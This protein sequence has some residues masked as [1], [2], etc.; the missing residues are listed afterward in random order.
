MVRIKFK[1]II[2]ILVVCSFTFLIGLFNYYMD[3][4]DIFLRKCPLQIN[5]LG[6]KYAN[7]M[8]K[9][10]KDDKH[11]TLFIGGSEIGYLFQFNHIVFNKYFDA[12]DIDY[13]SPKDLYHLVKNYIKLHPET[14]NIY[15]SIGYNSILGAKYTEIPEFSNR[16]FTFN[17][18]FFIFVSKQTTLESL[19]KLY[20]N[21]L[22][23]LKQK[24]PELYKTTDVIEDRG[25]WTTTFPNMPPVYFNSINSYKE[26]LPEK[27]FY[28]DQL[29]LFL[30]NNNIN[31]Q[32]IIPPYHSIYLSFLYL[33]KDASE[34]IAQ[35]KRHIVK[36]S[37]NG[38]YDFSIINK[39]TTVDYKKNKYLFAEY[40]HPNIVLGMKIFKYFHDN[41]SEKDLF[42]KLDKNNIEQLLRYENNL[43]KNYLDKNKIPDEYLN[44][45]KYHNTN[46]NKMEMQPV[47]YNNAPDYVKKEIQLFEY[48][49]MK[50]QEEIRNGQY[51]KGKFDSKF[52]TEIVD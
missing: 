52:F 41:I 9:A 18:L 31:Y 39:Y 26:M 28:L 11:D 32:I 51:Q 24:C 13:I 42:L 22:N 36:I 5:K 35:L 12:I 50:V 3:P 46:E 27:L 48:N 2:F 29:I 14:K 44:W 43:I 15:I 1:I 30:K 38:L 21:T 40:T 6:Q 8:L 16:N 49:N 19:K 23:F 47:Y 34:T 10:Y 7:A 25:F 33:N 4:Y 37:D 20:G 17:E 45:Y